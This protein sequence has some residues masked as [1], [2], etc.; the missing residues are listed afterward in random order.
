MTCQL[1][2]TL[3]HMHTFDT[4]SIKH[5]CIHTL[6]VTQ[7][8]VLFSQSLIV[9]MTCQ[10]KLDTICSSTFRALVAPWLCN[11]QALVAPLLSNF[12]ASVAP[13]LSNFQALVA[14]LLSN[15]Q[16]LVAP[17]S[18]NFQALVAP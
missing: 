7:L 13:L 2:N 5:T 14:P 18:S 3:T 10:H 17:L 9:D 4:H 11:F 16:A 6:H 12:Q 1:A 8:V 15:F